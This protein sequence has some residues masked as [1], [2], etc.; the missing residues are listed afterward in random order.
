M[1]C[2]GIGGSGLVGR[3]PGVG[4]SGLFGRCGA[5][6]GLATGFAGAGDTPDFTACCLRSKTGL[7]RTSVLSI[8]HPPDVLPNSI[9]TNGGASNLNVVLPSASCF[10]RDWPRVPNLSFVR[11]ATPASRSSSKPSSRVRR[12]ERSK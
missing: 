6:G 3:W 7:P 5:P 4:G 1:R 10:H 2:V 8:F 11:G 9:E 12:R